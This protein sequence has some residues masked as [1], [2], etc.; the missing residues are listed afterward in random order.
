MRN[1]QSDHTGFH[2]DLKSGQLHYVHIVVSQLRENV[3][4][5][6]ELVC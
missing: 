1:P 3:S 2:L 4:D 6:I 5:C